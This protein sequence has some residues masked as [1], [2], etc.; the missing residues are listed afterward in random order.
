[1][2]NKLIIPDEHGIRHG[3][4]L[5]FTQYSMNK[6]IEVDN[7]CIISIYKYNDHRYDVKCFFY[8]TKYI[9]YRDHIFS[10]KEMCSLLQDLV[11]KNCTA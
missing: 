2:I 8:K 10:K 1:M 9:Y 11:Y 5:N 3:Y 7:V 4:L 6:Y